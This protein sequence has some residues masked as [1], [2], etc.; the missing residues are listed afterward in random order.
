MALVDT[1]RAAHT[2]I[3]T[4]ASSAAV[5][6]TIGAITGSG[7]R[8]VAVTQAEM[9]GYGEKGDTVNSVWLNI[10]TF[11]SEP[12]RGSAITVAGAAC[13]VTE[14]QIDEAGALMRVDYSK[15]RPIT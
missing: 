14:T 2:S 4:L 6:V 12:V 11:T 10:A 8:A 1:V 7:I 15:T 3:L 13:Y 9:D 5:S